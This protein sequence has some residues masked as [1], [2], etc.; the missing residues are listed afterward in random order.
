MGQSLCKPN[1]A[2]AKRKDKKVEATRAKRSID[3]MFAKKFEASELSGNKKALLIGINYFDYNNTL[4]SCVNDAKNM[5]RALIEHYSFKENQILLLTDEESSESPTRERILGALEWLLDGAQRND[6]L[7]FY[8]SGHGLQE[9]DP[10]GIERD[11]LNE[12]ICP[13][14]YKTAGTIVDNVL[15][16]LVVNRLPEACRLTVIIDCY[17]SGAMLDLPYEFK[18]LD[19]LVP[20]PNTNIQELIP[21]D[22]I[23]LS[24]C[25]DSQT[26]ADLRTKEGSYASA[27][28]FS[29]LDNLKSNPHSITYKHLLASIKKDLF[30]L[31]IVQVPMISAGFPLDLETKFT[32]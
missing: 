4:D 16:D 14:D 3:S 29:F 24:G 10:T 26:S 9:R 2:C 27:F 28:T 22:V 8:F 17:H 25:Q 21:L 7:V 1:K 18:N 15:H 13:V 6:S 23:L 11:G 20:S 19:S 32:M 5:K 31:S 12:V 30:S